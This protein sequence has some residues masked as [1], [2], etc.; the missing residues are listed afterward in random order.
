MSMKGVAVTPNSVTHRN[1]D[2]NHTTTTSGMS[3][4]DL[5]PT[6][7]VAFPVAATV[8]ASA[9]RLPG[10]SRCPCRAISARA[11]PPPPVPRLCCR[12]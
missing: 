7:P 5:C 2:H 8:A 9:R 4:D 1:L 12:R 11:T 3:N 6:T 10:E